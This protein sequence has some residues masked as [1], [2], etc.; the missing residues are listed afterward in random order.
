[1]SSC[2][3][4]PSSS[5]VCRWL[6]RKPLRQLRHEDRLR[7]R[8]AG[9]PV[10]GD[11]DEGA[12]PGTR[13]H[14][15][16][17]EPARSHVRMGRGVL[18]RSASSS[19]RPATR[20]PRVKSARAHSDGTANY[21]LSRTR[22]PSTSAGTATASAA[23][24]CS[25]SSSSVR[26]ASACESSSS[27]EIENARRS[28]RPRPDRR[29]RRRQQPACANSTASGSRPTWPSAGTS[30]SG[31]G[32]AGYSTPSHSR[33]STRMPA[34][35]GV[36]R[37]DSTATTSTFIAECSP[38]TWAGLGFDRLGED[39]SIRLLEQTLREARSKAIP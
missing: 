30:T 11:P 36:T 37:T 38:E 39:D 19:S 31:W 25:T 16:R 28:A 29:L 7:R 9:W 22:S 14:G 3:L 17:A 10:P 6:P 35:S 1:M 15:L 33:S 34:G 21:W 27:S 12:R 20:P 4:K 18:G 23:S 5:E 13:D 26:R 32:R 24:A 8:R 2:F